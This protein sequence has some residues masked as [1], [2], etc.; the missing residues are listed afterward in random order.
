[1]N[2]DVQAPNPLSLEAGTSKE[3]PDTQEEH[4]VQAV[5]S[6]ERLCLNRFD[7]EIDRPQSIPADL[8]EQRKNSLALSPQKRLPPEILCKIFVDSMGDLRPVLPP[9]SIALPW[10]YLWVCSR[11][12]QVAL[13][14]YRLWDRVLALESSFGL[15]SSAV[16]TFLP[17]LWT[18]TQ[19]FPVSFSARIPEIDLALHDILSPH[20]HR[21]EKLFLY[22][23]PALI[24][25]FLREPLIPY[26]R[27]ESLGLDLKPIDMEL[28]P[29]DHT[30][31]AVFS[32]FPA[33]ANLIV[34]D[35]TSD[36]IGLPILS[37][38]PWSQL[39]S[40]ALRID[41]LY[42]GDLH[43]VL[44]QCSNLISLAFVTHRLNGY[45]Y[46][47]Y[48]PSG[49]E[50]PLPVL[51]SLTLFTSHNPHASDILDF[52]RVPSMEEFTVDHTISRESWNSDSY[53]SLTQ[54]S[55][56]DMLCRSGASL[57]SLSLL[58]DLDLIVKGYQFAELSS[59]VK[60]VLPMSIPIPGEIFEMMVRGE[61]L[62]KLEPLECFTQ[63]HIAFLRLLEYQYEHLASSKYRG[64]SFANVSYTV[65]KSKEEVRELINIYERL[66]PQLMNRKKV[67]LFNQIRDSSGLE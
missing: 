45:F 3:I 18:P 4:I 22:V 30:P 14:E 63:S 7:R 39:I 64:L 12:R 48:P 25:S 51:Q 35:D 8:Y 32:K 57:K 19:T 37:Q 47:D 49:P 23:S 66:R 62:G 43:C 50:I 59:L 16:S 41:H 44:G 33:L 11:W 21:L 15:E 67:I 38:I 29:A 6:D 24:R 36:V 9:S 55:F 5:L 10:V 13:A 65:P 46:R 53:P 61:V 60:L 56:D 40:V 28:T 27:L 17:L 34:V 1:M 20:S 52:L 2:E 58:G 31:V 54:N 42:F 26:S